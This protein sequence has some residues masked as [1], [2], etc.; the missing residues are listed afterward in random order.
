M[1][2]MCFSD[3]FNTTN[4]FSSAVKQDEIN[5]SFHNRIRV[6]LLNKIEREKCDLE[7]RNDCDLK[8]ET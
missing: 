7:V 4:V 5:P 2:A 6:I 1:E 3:G 8:F